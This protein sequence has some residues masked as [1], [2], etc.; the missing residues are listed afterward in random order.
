[1]TK[2]DRPCLLYKPLLLLVTYIGLLIVLYTQPVRSTAAYVTAL[3]PTCVNVFA[4]GGQAGP[5]EA[6]GPDTPPETPTGDNRHAKW[7]WPMMLFSSA[8]MGILFWWRR[9]KDYTIY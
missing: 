2:M 6:S 8:T 3:S 9:K 5:P 1:M 4:G 7:A